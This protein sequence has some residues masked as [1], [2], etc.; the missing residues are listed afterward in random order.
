[1]VSRWVKG[2]GGAPKRMQHRAGS[3]ARVRLWRIFKGGGGGGHRFQSTFSIE[4]VVKPEFGCD[5][6]S[7]GG[8]GFSCL[9]A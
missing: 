8:E 3:K 9:E 5:G 6:F 1:M 2:E 7:P 4:L